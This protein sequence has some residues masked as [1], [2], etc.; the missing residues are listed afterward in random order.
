MSLP[1]QERFEAGY[2]PEP[3][4]GCFLWFA[5]RDEDGYGCIRAEGKSSRAHRVAWIL[6]HG[7]IPDRLLACHRCDTPECVNVEHMWLGTN[8]QNTRDRHTKRRDASG[9]RNGSYTRPDRRPV[10]DRNGARTQPGIRAGSRHSQARLTETDVVVIRQ[11]YQDGET[12]LALAAAYEVSQTTIWGIV[13]RHR[14]RHV[15]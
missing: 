9:L 2:I 11:R 5:A 1:L 3:N 4:T 6:A 10:G 8:A 14:W 7:P 15:A 12:Q 13:T